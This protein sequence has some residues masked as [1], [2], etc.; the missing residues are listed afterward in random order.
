MFFKKLT[1]VVGPR[2]GMLGLTVKEKQPEI[3]L[4]AGV[5]TGITGA[6]MF[7]RAHKQSDEVFQDVQGEI[8]ATKNYIVDNNAANIVGPDG[9]PVDDW[10]EVTPA[11]ERKL[12]LPLYIE[13]GKRATILYG[14]SVLMGVA[15][16]ALILASHKGLQ[17]RNRA[18]VAT[19]TLLERS[20]NV[21]R[22]RVRAELGDEADERFY[23]GADA[24]KVN[25]V[26]VGEDGKKKKK[27]ETKN[28]IPEEYDPIMYQREFDERNK[29]WNPQDEMSEF[30]L[31][32]VEEHV[33][34]K[35]TIKGWMTLNEV[36][37]DLGFGA[38]PE[39]A[40]VGWSNNVPG[41]DFISFGIDNDINL[42]DGD[43]RYILDFNVNGLILNHI[44]EK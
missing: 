13:T 27:K 39:G 17:R 30:F 1:E 6:V 22:K 3:L 19:V 9:K 7:A 21:Y 42:R 26:T 36:Y 18:L 41:D 2:V 38:S 24:R 15:S 31:R 5:I 25:T 16:I 33:N 29:N 28:H 40:V 11:E 43:D 23:Y 32:M 14:P 35:L 4:T 12:L 37:D 44:G 20:F 34:G 8:E 10:D